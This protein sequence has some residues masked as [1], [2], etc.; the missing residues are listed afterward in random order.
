MGEGQGVR[1]DRRTVANTKVDADMK[2]ES[3]LT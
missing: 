1:A 3:E 2:L